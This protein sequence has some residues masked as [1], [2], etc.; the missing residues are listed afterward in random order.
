LVK[1]NSIA[2]ISMVPA[3]NSA[4]LQATHILVAQGLLLVLLAVSI[5]SILT[6]NNENSRWRSEGNC[7]NTSF[8]GWI[9]A[10]R[11]EKFEFVE[12]VMRLAERCLQ[13][14][15]LFKSKLSSELF[16]TLNSVLHQT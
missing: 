14:S 7:K 6:R 12:T 5:Y 4:E 9:K 15:K 10:R 3:A 13:A 11:R 16:V 1:E 8:V 2:A